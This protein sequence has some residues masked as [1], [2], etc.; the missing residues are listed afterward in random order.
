MDRD[1]GTKEEKQTGR[2]KTLA[3]DK[4]PDKREHSEFSLRDITA[5]EK[6]FRAS[7]DGVRRGN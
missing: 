7:W 6:R 2:N 5:N 4:R 1:L 3:T